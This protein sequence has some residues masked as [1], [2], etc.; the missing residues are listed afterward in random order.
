[1]TNI[2]SFYSME[3]FVFKTMKSFHVYHCFVYSHLF[4]SDWYSFLLY[5]EDFVFKTMK[6]FHVYHCLVYSQLAFVSQ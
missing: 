1:M 3:A 5:E 2:P 4:Q 6:R